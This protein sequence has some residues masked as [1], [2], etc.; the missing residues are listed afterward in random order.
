[1]GR[2]FI[3]IKLVIV[4]MDKY[5]YIVCITENSLYTILLGKDEILSSQS[6][7]ANPS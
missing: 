3:Y 6:I 7:T 1:M 4:D 2:Y 5:T